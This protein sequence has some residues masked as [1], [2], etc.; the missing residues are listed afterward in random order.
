[1]ATWTSSGP[2]SP[3]AS[4]SAARPRA[5]SAPRTGSTAR[6]PSPSAPRRR[7]RSRPVGG[8]WTTSCAHQR[9]D[10]W[11]AP[12]PGGPRGEAL[13]HVGDP[14]RQQGAGAVPRGDRR[15]PRAAAVS[16]ACARC[17]P[18][19]T[20]RRSSTGAASAG[21]RG[22]SR[23]S[24]STSGRASRGCSTSR[25]SCATQGV[26]FE[27]L[28]RGEDVTVPTPRRGLWKW[29]K[30]VV[31]TAMAPKAGALAWRLDQRPDDR[32]FPHGDAR[33]ARP[34]PRPGD[35]DVQRRRVPRRQEPRPGHRAVRGRGVPVLAGDPLLRVRRPGFADRLERVA[36]NALP[37]TFAP[38]MWAHQYDQQVNQVQCTINP[39][40]CGRRTAPS[41]T[42]TAS[43]RTSAA[44]RRTCT[45]AGPSSRRTCGWRRPD[46]GSPPWL[47]AERGS[48][49]QSGG[50]PVT[51]RSRPTI[52][53]ATRSRITVTAER[54]RGSRS[55]CACRLGRRR[56][57]SG[58]GRNPP[59]PCAPGTFHGSSGSGGHADA[60]PAVPH[61]PAGDAP[62]QRGALA[63]ERGPLVY[64][65][66]DRR[67]VDSCERR[68]AAPRAAARRL[69]SAA[70][71][72]VELRV[73]NW[74]L[75]HGWAGEIAPGPQRSDEPLEQVTLVPYG[76]TNIRV[77]EFPPLAG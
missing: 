50:A 8:T 25:G 39:S 17:S 34:V 71:D 40:T 52:R 16:R 44:A 7:R 51:V 67:G 61:A 38:D 22:W 76:C 18:A 49:F 6:S 4:G 19:S 64:S 57:P 15:R 55:C 32:A 5:G 48:E 21:T 56:H 62:V 60:G 1:V 3:T 75:E 45:R 26:D 72:T 27:A 53:S 68:Q 28:F 63:V 65:P 47:R 31:N 42:S 58:R 74:K 20:A 30:H 13:R 77:T 35:G 66:E 33:A 36:F 59:P 24:T 14:A 11:Y 69:R 46:G 29:T 73:V 43:S 23:R 41:R 37:A 70:R 12:V 10:G 2:T 9:P 54:G